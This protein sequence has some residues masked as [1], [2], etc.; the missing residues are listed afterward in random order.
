MSEEQPVKN[1][2]RATDCLAYGIIAVVIAVLIAVLIPTLTSTHWTS[3][4]LVPV[5][6]AS[7]F[8]LIC[9]FRGHTALHRIKREPEKH[10]GEGRCFCGLFVGYLL[11]FLGVVA[12]A[13]FL[14]DPPYPRERAREAVCKSNVHQLCLG[15][16]LCAQENSGA[17]PKT[18]EW[19]NVVSKYVG[20]TDSADTE[21]L[22]RYL[23]CP[24]ARRE[25]G[26]SGSE[27]EEGMDDY[28]LIPWTN[29]EADGLGQSE[30]PLIVES[31]ANHDG[32]RIVGYADGHVDMI[33]EQEF[34]RQLA[35]VRAALKNQGIDLDWSRR[36]Q[37]IQ[38]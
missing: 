17:L 20:M 4:I 37:S 31:A 7:P 11:V 25:R 9:L 27:S 12:F 18:D 33:G 8:A 24:A 28:I 2:T 16:M 13:G 21:G 15:L 22:Y 19:R 23:Q 32:K 14:L 38:D 10:G 6:F 1:T 26:A 34:H 5:V 3:D 36:V 29:L 30:M 35:E